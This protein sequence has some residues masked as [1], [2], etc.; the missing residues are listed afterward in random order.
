MATA[1]LQ[2]VQYQIVLNTGNISGARTKT[3]SLSGISTEGANDD[4]F[5][6]IGAALS[7]LF[8][9]TVSEFRKVAT[10]GVTQ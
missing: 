8:A 1:T 3:V 4:K 2:K 5:Y 7:P 9:L 6:A 10:S